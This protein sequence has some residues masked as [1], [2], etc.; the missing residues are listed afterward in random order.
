MHKELDSCLHVAPRLW[1]PKKKIG[2]LLA[3]SLNTSKCNYILIVIYQ[4]RKGSPIEV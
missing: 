2:T 4:P 1:K 3:P